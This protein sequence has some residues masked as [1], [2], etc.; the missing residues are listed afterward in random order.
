MLFKVTVMP[1]SSELWLA[2]NAPLTNIEYEV[3]G[4]ALIPFGCRVGACG[5]CAIEV[6]QG[7]ECLGERTCQ[8]ADFLT[9]LGFAGERFRLACQCRLG[10][11]ATFRVAT[12]E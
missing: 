1:T 8:E 7:L 9:A 10:G 6:T 12:P 2:A 11:D 5:A 4:E 3:G